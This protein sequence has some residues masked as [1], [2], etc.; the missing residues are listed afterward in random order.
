MTGSPVFEGDVIFKDNVN[1]TAAQKFTAAKNITLYKDKAIQVGGNSVIVAN[2]GNLVLVAAPI[3]PALLAADFAATADMITVGAAN[4]TINSGNLQV[5]ASRTLSINTVKA[6]LGSSSK[7]TLSANAGL[8]GTGKVIAGNTAITNWAVTTAPIVIEPN[9]IS[10]STAAVL[11]GDT[12]SLIELNPADP[13]SINTNTALEISNVDVQLVTGGSVVANS[14]ATATATI[15]LSENARISGL[16]GTGSG[17]N[18]I[19]V[20][21]T[22]VDSPYEFATQTNLEV[23]DGVGG[24]SG[25]NYLHQKDAA[26]GSATLGITGNGGSQTI[27]IDNVLPASAYGL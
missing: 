26:V 11:V 21:E 18:D 1:I 27:P 14:G 12:G 15:T 6:T 10:A 22:G 24:A 4:I 8:S 3:A 17:S 5:P 19:V 7:I 16:L 13:T 23:V 20:G 25:S 9:K 2:E